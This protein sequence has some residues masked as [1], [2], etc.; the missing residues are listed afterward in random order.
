MNDPNGLVAHAGRYH[1]FYQYN[2][3]GVTHGNMSWGHASSP[4]LYSWEHHPVAIPCTE[5][6]EIYSGSVVVDD[7]AVSGYGSAESPALLAFYTSLNRRTR[8]QAQ[9]VAYSLDDGL[10]WTPHA[11][12]PVLDRGSRNFRDPKVVRWDGEAEAYWVMVAVEAEEREV[13]LFRSDDLLTWA[14]LSVFG[15]VGS[16][17][18]IW[19]CPDLFPL[20][21]DGTGDQLWVLLVSLYP[22]APAG[23]SGTQYFVGHFDGTTFTPLHRPD[24]DPHDARWLDHGFDNY[25]GVTFFGLPEN[26]RTLIGWM[27]NWD[28]ARALPPLRGTLGMMTAPRRLSLVRDADGWPVLTQEPVLPASV[29]WTEYSVSGEGWA[30]SEA[31]PGAAVL[32]VEVSLAPGAKTSMRLRSRADGT[33]GVLVSVTENEITLDRTG[34]AGGVPQMAGVA[35]APRPLSGARVRLRI[36][37][38]EQSVEVFADE[39]TAVLTCRMLPEPDAVGASIDAGVG[40]TVEGIRLGHLAGQEAR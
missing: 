23:G 33:G 24:A 27:S 19:E 5:A 17:E 6:E 31:L 10:T 15:G 36:V 26:E 32:E 3:Y 29:S 18:G 25:A 35:R 30:A 34:A 20:A 4:D 37:L 39:G 11:G 40:V 12:N 38:D 1:L 22:G 28:Y 16:V 21:V 8:L 2:P 13:H 14:P 9:S 7:N